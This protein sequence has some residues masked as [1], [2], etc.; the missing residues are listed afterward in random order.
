[1]RLEY[2]NVDKDP[3]IRIY[4]YLDDTC[5]DKGGMSMNADECIIAL[6]SIMQECKFFG[7]TE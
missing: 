5:R 4:A 6:D 7:L 2:F 3:M 1:M